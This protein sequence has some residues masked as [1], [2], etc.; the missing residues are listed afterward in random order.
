MAVSR[1]I[2]PVQGEKLNAFYHSTFKTIISYGQGHGSV[3]SL[4]QADGPEIRIRPNLRKS[5]FF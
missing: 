1:F 5:M 3:F 2:L 4:E